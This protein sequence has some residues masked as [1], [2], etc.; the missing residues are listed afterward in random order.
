M[1]RMISTSGYEHDRTAACE[2]I[3]CRPIEPEKVECRCGKFS[4]PKG[5][6]RGGGIPDE[7]RNHSVTSCQPEKDTPEYTITVSYSL[8]NGWSAVVK[9]PDGFVKGSYTHANSNSAKNAAESIA[10]QHARS[11]QPPETY[12]F[13]PEI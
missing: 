3:G 8:E 13:T 11:Q 9:G 7:A 1:V 12:K 10:I 2:W 4:W 5:A 6:V